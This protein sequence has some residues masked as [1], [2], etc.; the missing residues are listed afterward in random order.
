MSVHTLWV[1]K[2]TGMVSI[3]ANVTKG[4]ALDA[5]P[6]ILRFCYDVNDLPAP[7]VLDRPDLQYSTVATTGFGVF[8]VAGAKVRL[9]TKC[10]CGVFT[11]RDVDHADAHA[12]AAVI[13]TMAEVARSEPDPAEATELTRYFP[14]ATD[15]Q[16][17][18]FLA[19]N[20]VEERAL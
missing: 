10:G 12:T 9:Q 16:I 7:L 5:G 2:D 4:E 14:D 13:A 6:Q 17:R 18:L 20:V 19:R 11:D 8:T 1:D 15:E 3:A